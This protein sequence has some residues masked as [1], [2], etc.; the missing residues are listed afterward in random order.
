MQTKVVTTQKKNVERIT[1]ELGIILSWTKDNKM[2]LDE[3]MTHKNTQKSIENKKK[4]HFHLLRRYLKIKNF[5]V[6]L[7][8]DTRNYF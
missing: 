5:L 2:K 3:K 7:L 4:Q 1:F 8:M 6:F